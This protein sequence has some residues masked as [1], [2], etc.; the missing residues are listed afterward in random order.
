MQHDISDTL[1]AVSVSAGKIIWKGGSKMI[2]TYS[3]SS[4]H[5]SENRCP[6]SACDHLFLFLYVSMQEQHSVMY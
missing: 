3:E 2:I 4:D 1:C 5:D 6:V